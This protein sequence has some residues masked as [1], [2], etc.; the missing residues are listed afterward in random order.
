MGA[1]TFG[2]KM[3][4]RNVNGV[5]I[6]KN[7]RKKIIEFIFS[8]SVKANYICPHSFHPLKNA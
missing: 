5:C 2:A 4:C 6:G 3:M 7:Y 1:G 8:Q